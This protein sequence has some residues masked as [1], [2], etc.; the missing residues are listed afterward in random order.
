[1]FPA[2]VLGDFAGG[3]MVCAYGIVAALFERTN[4][5]KGQVIDTA[6]ADGAFYLGTFVYNVR[7]AILSPFST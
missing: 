7:F 3:S 5:G 2:N 4:S 1:M 6:I